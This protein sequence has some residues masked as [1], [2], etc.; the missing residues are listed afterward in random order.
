MLPT[1]RRAM[2]LAS[3]ILPVIFNPTTCSANSILG[4][5]DKTNRHS[6]LRWETHKAL[7]VSSVYVNRHGGVPSSSFGKPSNQT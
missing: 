1:I 5:V 3:S 7:S 2:C 6:K 4:T